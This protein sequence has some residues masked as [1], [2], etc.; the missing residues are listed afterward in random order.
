MN[1]DT[2]HILNKYLVFIGAKLL[3]AKSFAFVRFRRGMIDKRHRRES[4][5]ATFL[6]SVSV[7][8]SLEIGKVESRAAANAITSISVPTATLGYFTRLLAGEHTS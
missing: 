4:A 7:A 1:I 6:T 2:I 8:D 3:V 5:V